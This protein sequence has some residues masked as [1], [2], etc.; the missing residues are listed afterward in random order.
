MAALVFT[1]LLVDEIYHRSELSF[2]WL[3]DDA[4]FICVLDDL[5]LGFF[6]S[7]MTWETAGFELAWTITLVLQ[8]NRLTKHA[9]HPK[10]AIIVTYL[11]F[12]EKK[13]LLD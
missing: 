12:G 4:M 13:M 1:R 10:W 6:H 11:Y 9:S 2:D 7:G 8:A 5:S 3:T